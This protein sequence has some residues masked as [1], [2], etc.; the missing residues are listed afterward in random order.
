MGV[1]PFAVTRCGVEVPYPAQLHQA[2]LPV[3]GQGAHCVRA[4]QV[5]VV[6]G[7][8][9]AGERQ[10]LARQWCPAIGP[11]GLG[12]GVVLRPGG[13]EVRRGG[14][15]RALDRTAVA[16]RPVRDHEYAGAVGDQDHRAVDG[17]QFALDGLDPRRQAQLVLHQWRHAAYLGQLRGQQGLPVFRHVVPQARDYEDGGAVVLVHVITLLRIAAGGLRDAN[18]RDVGG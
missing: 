13:V 5:V 6:A 7:A 4:G 2:A 1:R 15:Q 11:E 10:R 16:R 14:Q 3:L 8:D 9:Q 12:A 18:I 17:F